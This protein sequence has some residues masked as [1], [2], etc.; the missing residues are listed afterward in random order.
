MDH[1]IW[2]NLAMFNGVQED[3]HPP[4]EINVIDITRLADIQSKWIA[5]GGCPTKGDLV[6]RTEV[7]QLSVSFGLEYEK[8]TT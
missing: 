3:G 8:V 6:R 4:S 7:K 5:S 1:K 2:A